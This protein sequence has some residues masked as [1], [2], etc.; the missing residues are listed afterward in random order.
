MINTKLPFWDKRPFNLGIGV[1]DKVVPTKVVVY[2]PNNG[3][4]G[5]I[6]NQ[7]DVL[8]E[9]LARDSLLP[10]LRQ[11]AKAFTQPCA[12]SS[13]YVCARDRF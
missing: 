13:A 7:A 12:D 5:S 10:F 4:N 3:V 8:A 2:I 6:G 9:D 1:A 11:R